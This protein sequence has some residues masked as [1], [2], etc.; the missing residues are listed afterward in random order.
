MPLE[1]SNLLLATTGRGDSPRFL[2]LFRHWDQAGFATLLEPV[3]FA[4]DIHGSRMMQQPIENGRSDDWI[5]KD[6]TPFAVA[7]V[8]GQ[9][10][11]AS[12]VTGTDQLDKIVAPSSSSG[13]YP[14]S[15]MMSTLGAR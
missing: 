7:F 4:A 8:R 13:K 2:L 11:A 9:D 1:N 14:I 10:D 6:R 15:S 5:A 3:A 12:F